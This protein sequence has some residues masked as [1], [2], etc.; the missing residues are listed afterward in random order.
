M[1]SSDELLQIA[2]SLRPHAETLEDQP[3]KTA[4]DGIHQAFQKLNNA[5]S[6]S[7][8]G[9]HSRLYYCDFESPPSSD[10]FNK[11]WGLI[12]RI[13]GRSPTGWTE[14]NR[15]EVRSHM[16][17]CAGIDQPR[18]DILLQHSSAACECLRSAKFDAD[19]VLHLETQVMADPFLE[20][21][22]R[23][24][25]DLNPSSAMEFVSEYWP[26]G[27]QM[28][29]DSRAISEG[30]LLPGHY[31]LFAQVQSVESSLY[32]CVQAAQLC[33]KAV[34]HIERRN[35]I[36]MTNSAIQNKIFIGHG[37][38]HLWRELKDFVEVRL[39][40]PYEEFNRISTAGVPIVER[41]QE[42]LD[43]A[44]FALIL[45]TAEDETA[46]GNTQPRMN[47]IHEAGLFQGKLGFRK[48][49]VLLE[50]GCT[51]FS[52][53]HGLG[54]IRFPK[55]NVSSCFEEIRKVLEREGIL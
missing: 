18:F 55:G 47:V 30:T 43:S 10:P 3:V 12:D 9:Y 51:E 37:K 28:T 24:L 23:S 45:A 42:M 1:N 5:F 40:L 44:A 15:D 31:E 39:G 29:R 50:E 53:I 26:K 41:L 13:G 25:S 7:W 20:Q 52:N 54:Q 19:S 2:E 17:M 16:L 14:Y 46:D 8:L 4:I 32:A 36:K 21:L 11:E 38:S 27:Q 33:E 35:R 34:K 49:V 6:G 48:A 22:K